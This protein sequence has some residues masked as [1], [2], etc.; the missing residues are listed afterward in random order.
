MKIEFLG[1]LR[2]VVGKRFV[3]LNL[4]GRIKLVDLFDRLDAELRKHVVDESGKPVPGVLVLVNGV[5]VRFLSWLETEVDED[6]TVT[7]IPSIHGGKYA[8]D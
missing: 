6:D 8:F 2:A 5:D 4:E 7:L 1:P 3:E